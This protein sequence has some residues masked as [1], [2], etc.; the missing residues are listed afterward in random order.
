MTE[1]DM[2]ENKSINDMIVTKGYAYEY[3]GGKKKP[4]EDWTNTVGYLD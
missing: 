3:T 4:F 1:K 2:S